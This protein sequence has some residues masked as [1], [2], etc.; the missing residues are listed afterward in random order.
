MSPALELLLSFSCDAP[1]YDNN[2]MQQ[3]GEV[4]RVFKVVSTI[5]FG[6]SYSVNPKS[7]R[8]PIKVEV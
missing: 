5:G 4:S 2:S 6:Q 8:H 1:F 3:I 7:R